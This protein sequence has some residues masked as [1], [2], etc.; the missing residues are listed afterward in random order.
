MTTICLCSLS[1]VTFFVGLL[2]DVFVYD[3]QGILN[4]EIWRIATAALVHFSASHMAWNLVALVAVGG[5]VEMFGFK[6]L[7]ALFGFTSIATGLFY[8]TCLPELAHYGGLSGFATGTVVFFCL[9][10]LERSKSNGIWYSILML[11]LVKILFE[12]YSSTAA[13]MSTPG[14]TVSILP[15]AHIFGYLGAVAVYWYHRSRRRD[16]AQTSRMFS[17]QR[18][19]RSWP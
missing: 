10:S 13:F 4:G 1:V 2:S 14:T 17:P 8:V 9:C 11:T 6:G 7:W 5:A 19:L 12:I 15:S 3:R 16:D 18:S